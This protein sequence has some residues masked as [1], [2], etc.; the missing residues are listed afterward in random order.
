MQ[1]AMRELMARSNDPR[2]PAGYAAM[3]RRMSGGYSMAELE[4]AWA[5]VKPTTHWKDPIHKKIENT[6]ENRDVVAAAIEFFTATP[7]KFF[8]T[9]DPEV[10][11]VTA[12]GY[13]AGPAGDH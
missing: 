10:V 5:L 3:I 11:I 9:P 2:T 8:G 4:A 7:A 6:P 1:E 13:R 12:A